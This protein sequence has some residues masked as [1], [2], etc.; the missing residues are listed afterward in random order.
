MLIRE[1]G[2]PALR[3]EEPAAVPKLLRTA[4]RLATTGLGWSDAEEGEEDAP[5]F[6]ELP[7]C[8]S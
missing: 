1:V 7:W 2:L 4:E 8:S 3:A 6:A 5:A